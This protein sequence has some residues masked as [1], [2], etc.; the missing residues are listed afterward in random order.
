MIAV[1]PPLLTEEIPDLAN[2]LDWLLHRKD[3]AD[4]AATVPALRV[5][6]IKA[7]RTEGSLYFVPPDSIERPPPSRHAANDRSRWSFMYHP[8]RKRHWLGRAPRRR[9]Y[10][11][12]E[13]IDDRIAVLHVAGTAG[14]LGERLVQLE[15]EARNVAWGA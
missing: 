9:W 2:A 8:A 10:L 12:V 1:S 6:S 3:L 14:P 13:D 15:S 5:Y 7:G 4:L 11:V